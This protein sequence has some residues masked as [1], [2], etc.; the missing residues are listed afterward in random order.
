MLVLSRAWTWR[1]A[2]APPTSLANPFAIAISVLTAIL[3]AVSA[4][5]RDRKGRTGT[6]RK[7]GSAK[8]LIWPLEGYSSDFRKAIRSPIWSGSSRNSGMPGCPVRNPSARASSSVSTGYL[9][10]EVRKGGASERGL[11]PTGSM[12][13][14]CAQFVR[15]ITR[16][17]CSAGLVCA[18]DASAVNTPRRQSQ[19][20]TS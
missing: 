11:G 9:S 3:S 14:H 13:W 8:P 5:A 4:T 15:A 18:T 17:R 12:E 2:Q 20:R 6:N 7:C 16:P 1:R 10:C 19:A